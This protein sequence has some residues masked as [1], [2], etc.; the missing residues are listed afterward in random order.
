MPV[1]EDRRSDSE[2]SGVS[3]PD[4]SGSRSG[5]R[6]A[7]PWRS[8]WVSSSTRPKARRRRARSARRRRSRGSRARLLRRP[9]RSDSCVRPSGSSLAR[10][11]GHDTHRSIGGAGALVFAVEAPR[12]VRFRPAHIELRAVLEHEAERQP[13]LPIPFLPPRADELHRFIRASPHDEPG[14]LVGA[15]AGGEPDTSS[16]SLPNQR[17]TTGAHRR[18]TTPTTEGS[19]RRR[20]AGSSGSPAPRRSRGRGCRRRRRR[21]HP[22]SIPVGDRFLDHRVHGDLLPRER[23]ADG[24]TREQDAPVRS[25]TTPRSDD[26]PATNPAEIRSASR[27]APR[28]SRR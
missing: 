8:R 16:G 11:V 17:P 20:A 28:A 13:P 14:G 3:E 1:L 22:T 21:E 24:E 18:K 25:R 5:P 10:T 19:P 6:W 7:R 4:G 12:A 9:A 27:T 26:P 15:A 2:G 23:Q